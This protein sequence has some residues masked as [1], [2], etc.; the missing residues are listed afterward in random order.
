MELPTQD[1]LSELQLHPGRELFL[2]SCGISQ[3][4]NRLKA[5]PFLVPFL[6]LPRVSSSLVDTELRSDFV[7]PCLLC[8]PM[9]AT[10][11]VHVAQAASLAL[12]RRSGVI[13][14]A[15]TLDSDRTLREKSTIQVVYID[16]ST[17][18]EVVVRSSTALR[19]T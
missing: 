16:V 4:Y 1:L 7:V 18:S 5:P 8:I 2:A 13:G 11:A 6:G 15:L 3:Y 14:H 17:V 9:G 12:V 19:P 10:F